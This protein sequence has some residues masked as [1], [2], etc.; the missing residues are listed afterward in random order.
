MFIREIGKIVEIKVVVLYFSLDFSIRSR[1]VIVV[2]VCGHF[3]INY[4]F[5]LLHTSKFIGVRF[6]SKFTTNTYLTKTLDTACSP[7]YKVIKLKLSIC[8]G[9]NATTLKMAY[10]TAC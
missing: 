8:E 4:Y 5:S 6:E 7:L 2:N 1:F 10:S 3:N 9:Q